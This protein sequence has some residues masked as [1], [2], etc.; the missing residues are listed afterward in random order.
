M[1]TYDSSNVSNTL[2]WSDFVLISPGSND[3]AVLKWNNTSQRWVENTDIKLDDS[4]YSDDITLG[5][6]IIPRASNLS[7]GRSEVIDLKMSIQTL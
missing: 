1:L 3:G 4:A 6:S 7:L 2:Y 5:A